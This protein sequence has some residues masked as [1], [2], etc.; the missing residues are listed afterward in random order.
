MIFGIGTD[1][2]HIPRIAASLNRRGD[3]FASRILTE[4]E[5]QAY[6]A[7]NKPEHFLAKR[8]AAKEAVA[9]ALG[10]GF[11]NGLSLQHI[12]IAHNDAG[13][14]RLVFHAYGRQLKNELGIGESHL[15][16]SDEHE[17]A[18]AFVILM[19]AR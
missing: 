18:I 3:R 14:P 7:C 1:I 13:K 17:H 12:E 4:H 10:T 15:S 9:K 8:F 11:R 16:L 19:H 2:V 6:L 5:Y